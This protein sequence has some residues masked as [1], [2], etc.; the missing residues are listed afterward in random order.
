M[1]NVSIIGRIGQKP[2]VRETSG[3]KKVTTFSIAI[4]NRFRDSGDPDWVSIEVWGPTGEVVAEHKNTG[5]QVAVTGRLT[6]SKWTDDDGTHI[7]PTVTA[8]VLVRTSLRPQPQGLVQNDIGSWSKTT[9]HVG[10]KRHCT[11]V[12]KQPPSSGSTNRPKQQPSEQIPTG[13]CGTA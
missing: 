8:H 3:G 9:L 2:E 1:N 6:S 13:R 7:G 5:D 12:Q 11:L 4:E 10:P